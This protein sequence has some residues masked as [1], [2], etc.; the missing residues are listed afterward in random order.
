[1]KRNKENLE[2]NLGA[3]KP[4]CKHRKVFLSMMSHELRAPLAVIQGS[5]DLLEDGLM[6]QSG[7]EVTSEINK[8]RRALGRVNGILKIFL[9]REQLNR[10]FK[11]E[12]MKMIRP[13]E[14]ICSQVEKAVVLWP[15][16]KFLVCTVDCAGFICAD[17]AYLNIAFNNLFDNAAN[18]SMPDTAISVECYEKNGFLFIVIVN[19][20][21]TADLE[22]LSRYYEISYRGKKNKYSKPGEGVGLWLTCQ[23]V[24]QEGGALSLDL[25]G[26]R[27]KVTVCLP[28]RTIKADVNYEQ[29]QR[30]VNI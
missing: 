17:L 30:A 2:K 13:Q 9:D 27:F 16:R 4:S 6:C 28:M 22:E 25:D 1:M 29:K 26:D 21:D 15:E 12:R 5:L 8:I 18:Y 23:I 19:Q 20:T 3:E 14:F 10:D 24:E 7:Q 11:K